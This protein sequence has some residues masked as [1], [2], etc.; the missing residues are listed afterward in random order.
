[1][2]NLSDYLSQHQQQAERYLRKVFE[3]RG[4]HFSKLK[5]AMIY[6]LLSGGKRFRPILSMA[7]AEAVGGVADQ[8]LPF[9]CAIELIHTFSLIHDDLPAM[10]NDDLRRGKPTNHK[11]F[12]EAHAVLAGDA[13]LSEAFL[14]MARQPKEIG[15]SNEIALDIVARV[16]T[17]AGLEGMVGGQSLDLLAENADVNLAMLELIHLHK[18]AALISAS[19]YAGA[20]AGGGDALQCEKLAEYGR[21]IG[22]AFQVADDILNVT[23]KPEDLGK[24]IGSDKQRG[25]ATYPALFGVEA[26]RKKAFELADR[27]IA[28]LNDFSEDLSWPLHKLARFVVERDR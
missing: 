6:S 20:R 27:A 24:A 14:L 1:M 11:V 21:L 9:G 2:H 26:S 23:G 8:A 22:L 3:E 13:L 5:E 25:K 28:V 10:D 19:T 18:T 12:G 17:A 4:H 15:V 16:A 7:C